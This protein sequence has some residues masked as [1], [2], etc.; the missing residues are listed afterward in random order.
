[1]L[2]WACPSHFFHEV[3]RY[4]CLECGDCERMPESLWNSLRPNNLSNRHAFLH[5]SQAVVRHHGHSFCRESPESR[6]RRARYERDQAR[7]EL[8]SGIGTARKAPRRRFCRLSM[9]ISLAARS[10]RLGVRLSTSEMRAPVYE[11]VKQKLRTSGGNPS[12]CHEKCRPLC[13]Q[14]PSVAMAIIEERHSSAPFRSRRVTL[15]TVI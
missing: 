3:Y 1:M 15:G 10:M 7:Q 9:I 13:D 5:A 11:S 14:I 2:R 12:G 4:T 8:V 6:W